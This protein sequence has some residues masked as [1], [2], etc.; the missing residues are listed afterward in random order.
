MSGRATLPRRRRLSRRLADEAQ[1]VGQ[2]ERTADQEALTIRAA[3]AARQLQLLGR[4]DPFRRCLDP[5]ARAEPGDG[6]HDRLALRAVAGVSNERPVDLDLVE[7][8]A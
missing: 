8:E 7:G 1:Q 2:R 3:E 6:T 4:L 5:K